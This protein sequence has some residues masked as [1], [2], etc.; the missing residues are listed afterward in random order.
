MRTPAVCNSNSIIVSLPF[1]AHREY[2]TG[3][4]AL[5]LLAMFNYHQTPAGFLSVITLADVSLEGNYGGYLLTGV[6][7]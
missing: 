1:P 7:C 4:I 2:P 3:L 6:S 5:N